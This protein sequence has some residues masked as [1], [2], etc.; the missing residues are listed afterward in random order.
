MNYK[1]SY[2]IIEKIFMYSYSH[3]VKKCRDFVPKHVFD[4]K[5]II[6]YG[7]GGWDYDEIEVDKDPERIYYDSCG[8]PYRGGGLQR[9]FSDV[10]RCQKK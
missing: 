8:N 7:D 10:C 1:L 4:K 3:V 9:C 2:D 5:I 6:D